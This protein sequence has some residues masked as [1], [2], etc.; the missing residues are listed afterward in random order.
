MK[1]SARLCGK[2]GR[3]Q[4]R[5]IMRTMNLATGVLA[6]GLALCSMDASRA[7]L[8]PGTNSPANRPL[9]SWQFADTNWLSAKGYA[10]LNFT[11]IVNVAGD[12]AAG[13]DNDLWLDTTNTTPAFLL[14]NVVET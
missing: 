8:P 11:N 13:Y 12:V 10:P 14:Y 2:F 6:A 9:D 1:T 4:K 7:Q 5:E 3:E